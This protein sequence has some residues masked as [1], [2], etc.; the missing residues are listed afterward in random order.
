LANETPGWGRRQIEREIESG[1]RTDVKLASPV[2]IYW[3]YITAWSTKSGV[4]QFR[5]DIYS[6][7]GAEQ[8]ALGSWE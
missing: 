8:L 1:N 5:D 6:R 4:V 3:N 2:P 7:D